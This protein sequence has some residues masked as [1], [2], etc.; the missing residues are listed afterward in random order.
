MQSCSIR[1]VIVGC[2]LTGLLL[3]APAIAAAQ[4][5]PQWTSGDTWKVG[6]WQGQIFRPGSSAAATQGT[7]KMKGRV[8]TIDFQVNGETTVGDK[9]CWQ[10]QITYPPEQVGVQRRFVACYTKDTGRLVQITDV[11]VRPDG[12]TKDSTRTYS[13]AASGPT[14]VGDVPSLVPLDWPDF[15]QADSTREAGKATISQTSKSGGQVVLSKASG[16][17]EMKVEQ[18]WVSGQPWWLVA[19]KYRNGKLVTEAALLEVNG[20]KVQGMPQ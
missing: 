6:V 17:Y 15:S 14:I 4:T 7:Y 10:V 13:A 1:V 2:T 18:K 5:A 16:N 12:S 3:G 9:P 8:V 20:K 19:K 11:S